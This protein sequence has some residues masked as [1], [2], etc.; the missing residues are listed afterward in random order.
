MNE[1][2]KWRK[3]IVIGLLVLVFLEFF[4]YQL[5][6]KDSVEVLENTTIDPVEEEFLDQKEDKSEEEEKTELET[7]WV[8]IKGEVKKP[9]A[10]EMKSGTR[11]IDAIK[12][13]GGLTK[14]ANT[15]AN[16]LSKRL[17]DEMLIIVY[18]KKE[19]DELEVT[20]EKEEKIKDKCTMDENDSCNTE[21]G[22]LTKKISIN[23]ASLEEL[24]LLPGIKEA[25]AQSILEYRKT[26]SFEQLEDLM[27]VPG[28]KENL[29][30]QIKPYITL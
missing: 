10:Y 2:G 14:N 8:D 1:K 23:T 27:K 22:T 26:H 17:V 19:I 5:L 12:K 15:K 3:R 21:S 7:I 4:V 25:K 16:N 30:A 24:M 18:S 9:G 13:A 29:Y 11:V 20:M 6:K 28:I